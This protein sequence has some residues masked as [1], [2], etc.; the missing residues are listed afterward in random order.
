MTS[1]SGR[2]LVSASLL[3][4][5][6]AVA[7]PGVAAAQED[8]ASADRPMVR[9]GA[10]DKPYLFGGSRAALGGYVE[11]HFRHSRADGV[12]EETT[13]VPK[14][15]NLFLSSQISDFV[16]FFAEIEFE[17]GAEEILLEMASID[18]LIAREFGFRGGMLLSPLGRFNLSHDSP[19]NEF[20]DRPLVS[21]DVIGVALSEPGFGAFG[22]VPTGGTGRLT[23]ELYAVN[24]YDDGLIEDSPDGTRI[25]NGRRNFEDNNNHPSLVG[26]AAWSPKLDYEIGLSAHHGPYN[27]YRLDGADVD[28]KRNLSIYVLDFE[29]KLLGVR[30]QGEGALARIDIPESLRPLYARRQLGFFLEGMYDFGS[31]WI[32]TMPRSFFSAGARIDVIDLDEDLPGDNINQITAGFNFRP[33]AETVFKLDYVRGRARNRFNNSSDFARLL[34]SVATYF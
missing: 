21:T 12:T 10:Y 16:R 26:R 18:L 3:L 33:T 11:G 19:L 29:A 15:L 25:P 22:L 14:R 9:G 2:S 34:F 32:R 13:F 30:L 23:Y 4:S 17:D 31:G 8:T 7:L 20:T 5:A 27:I 28:Q 1:V 24:G 6:I